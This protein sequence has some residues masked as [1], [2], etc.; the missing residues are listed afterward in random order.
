MSGK[1]AGGKG[2]CPRPVNQKK[3]E[4]NFLRCFGEE[5][6]ACGGSGLWGPGII[7]DKCNGIGYVERRK[8]EG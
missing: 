4:E 5:C 3:F 1:W 8:V 7:C 2:D 6:D